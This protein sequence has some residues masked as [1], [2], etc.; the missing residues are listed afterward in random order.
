MKEA[1]KTAIRSKV[2]LSFSYDNEIRVVQATKLG[3]LHNG[4]E[5]MEAYLIRGYSKTNSPIR[6]RLY[7]L[8][9]ME[10]VTLTDETFDTVDNLYNSSDK[11]FAHIEESLLF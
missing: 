10:E 3:R 11:R 6:W 2:L 7:K 8:N 5:A 1:I 4:T 9:N